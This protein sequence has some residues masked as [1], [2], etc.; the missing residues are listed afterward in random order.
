MVTLWKWL[1]LEVLLHLGLSVMLTW[2]FDKTITVITCMEWRND[3]NI[4][5]L[6]QVKPEICF[7]WIWTTNKLE[8]FED[9]LKKCSRLILSYFSIEWF[10][11]CVNFVILVVIWF[12]CK[13]RLFSSFNS[14]IALNIWNN[15]QPHSLIVI[16]SV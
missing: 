7:C 8:I 11:F 14:I 3:C 5:K 16:W 10:H 4:I 12:G 1:S 6:V 9:G 2:N 15:K 13:V